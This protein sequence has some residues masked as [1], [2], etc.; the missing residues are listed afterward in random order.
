MRILFV[1]QSHIPKGKE[2]EYLPI[3]KQTLGIIKRQSVEGVTVGVY[4]TDDGSHYLRQ[5]SSDT[6]RELT[7]NEVD[8]I[9]KLKKID[10]DKIITCPSS[11][12]FMKGD[13]FNCVT[14][15]YGSSYDL[16]IFMD[17]D[18][19][20]IND[21][22]AQK[23]VDGFKKGYNFIVG[24][25]SQKD[26][27]LFSFNS[28]YVQGT[29]YAVTPALLAKVDYFSPEIKDWGLGDDEDIFWKIYQ[30]WC[31]GN[32]TALFAGDI[33]SVQKISGRWKYCMNSTGGLEAFEKKFK[34]KYD[35][36]PYKNNPSMLYNL[37]MDYA[38]EIKEQHIHLIKAHEVDYYCSSSI[39]PLK[40]F[41]KKLKNKLYSILQKNENK[42]SN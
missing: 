12:Y 21:K 37:W 23:F 24:R 34:N 29:T 41:N 6:I 9:K 28:H 31:K 3:V 8:E 11:R 39:K 18:Q 15:R 5:Y 10:V 4:L 32:V 42:K 16:V 40:I 1:V 36:E 27:T 17:D 26:G 33:I 25:L 7:S 20:F 38:G 30:E 22:A 2:D 14:K 19:H 13:L 35:Q